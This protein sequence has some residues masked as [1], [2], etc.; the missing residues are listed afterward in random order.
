MRNIIAF[1]RV[2]CVFIALLLIMPPLWLV[3][4]TKFSPTYNWIGFK[5]VCFFLGIKIKV[6][7]GKLSKTKKLLILSN[8]ISYLDIFAFG[9]LVKTNFIAKEDV[10]KWPMFGTLATWGNTVYISRDRMKAKSQI[11]TIENALKKNP[12]PIV[13]YPEGTSSNGNE[14]FPFKSSMFA[15]FEDYHPENPAESIKIQPISIAYTYKGK[16]RTNEEDRKI[17]AFYIK[18]QTFI[19]NMFIVAKNTPCTM[20]VIFHDEIDVEKLHMNRKELAVYTHDIVEKGFNDLI[21]Q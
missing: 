10:K 15:M 13:I 2:F 11:N 19:A 14:M 6:R 9:S 20:E 7:K 21:N 3:H 4:K 8:H 18:E 5:I 12:I 1:I 16:K 17:F